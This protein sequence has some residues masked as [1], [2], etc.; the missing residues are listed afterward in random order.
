M[1]KII[2]K[3]LQLNCP[4][5]KAFLYFTENRLLEKWLALRADVVPEPGGK[6]ELFW[7]PDDPENN[8]TK[9]CRILALKKNRYLCF[10]WT[11]PEQF[12]HFMNNTRPLTTV[13]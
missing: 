5:E 10:E 9:G 11:G 12:K 7:K 1:D 4:P 13:T 8:S 2:T 3:E 6:Y